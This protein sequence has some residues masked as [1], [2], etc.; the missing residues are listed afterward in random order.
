ML[1]DTE[2]DSSIRNF[3]LLGILLSFPM[4]WI[5]LGVPVLLVVAFAALLALPMFI[6]GAFKPAFIKG[7]GK[8]RWFLNACL[9][10]FGTVLIGFFAL[11][12]RM[13]H[14]AP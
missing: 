13:G 6:K 14:R 2:Q 9:V 3:C 5:A 8:V 10:A 12:L 4:F 7:S 11:L 1:L